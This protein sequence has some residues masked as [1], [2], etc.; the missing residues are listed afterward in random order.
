MFWLLLVAIAAEPSATPEE[1]AIA[2]LA[3]EV[4][5]WSADNK[6]FSCHNNGDAARA[7][8]TAVKLSYR[9]PAGALDDTSAWLATPD[10]WDQN[11]GEGPFSDRRLARIQFAAALRTA[12]ETGAQ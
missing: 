3:R 8:Y 12:V 6:C 1:R 4:P 11:G 2:Y 7:L 9:V 5:R 10:R